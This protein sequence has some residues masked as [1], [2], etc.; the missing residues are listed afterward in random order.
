MHHTL[1]LLTSAALLQ[2]S[3]QVGRMEEEASEAGG[4]GVSLLHVVTSLLFLQDFSALEA[5]ELSWM[6]KHVVILLCLHQVHKH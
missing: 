4:Q 5:R 2:M 1:H 3:Y 6:G